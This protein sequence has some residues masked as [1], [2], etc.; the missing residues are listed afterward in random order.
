[1]AIA[2]H[3]QAS[4][5]HRFNVSVL[6]WLIYGALCGIGL[7]FA[8]SL[9][10]FA[11][12][13]L[14]VMKE[15]R[16]RAV[17]IMDLTSLGYFGTATIMAASPA[18]HILETYHL[19]IVWSAFALVAWAT[20]IAGLPFTMQYAREQSPPEAWR[21]PLFRRINLTLTLVW[22]SIFTLGAVLG[23]ATLVADH[24]FILGA[25]IP[26]AG[27]TA[28]FIFNKLYLKRFTDQFTVASISSGALGEA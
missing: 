22:S 17:K 3:G 14:I 4:P 24:K 15:R 20:L 27:M 23:A 28:G 18:V 7:W 6:A 8:G 5:A 11:A 9:C 1:M 26:G 16:R 13:A 21:T 19:V 12:M 2:E 25:V 10:G